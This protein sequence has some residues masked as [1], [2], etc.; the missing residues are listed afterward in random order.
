MGGDK[1]SSAVECV[2]LLRFFA[3]ATRTA[4]ASGS[5]AKRK[6]TALQA[7]EEIFEAL[8]NGDMTV[9]HDYR[10]LCTEKR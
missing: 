7:K 5:E 2:G 8:K 3:G 4:E 9:E 10:R 6:L 1:S